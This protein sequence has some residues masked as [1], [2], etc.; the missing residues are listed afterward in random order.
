MAIESPETPNPEIDIDAFLNQIDEND[1][2]LIGTLAGMQLE[3]QLAG[4]VHQTAEDQLAPEQNPN[5]I[6]CSFGA[7]IACKNSIEASPDIAT[8]ERQ[9][10]EENAFRSGE[11]A[12]ERFL[13]I[14]EKR[15][16]E[17]TAIYS[18]YIR[19]SSPIDGHNRLS[20]MRGDVCRFFCENGLS[21][22]DAAT[23]ILVINELVTNYIRLGN[24]KTH[25]RLEIGQVT[26][27]GRAII[28]SHFGTELTK[29]E[30]RREAQLR[31]LEKQLTPQILEAEAP[32][33]FLN[34]EVE[35]HGLGSA[36]LG[37]LSVPSGIGRFPSEINPGNIY[38]VWVI[39]Q[40]A[41][42]RQAA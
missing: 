42:L 1:P 26:E 8:T 24:K 2:Q 13:A 9:V 25:G 17:Y 32:A 10:A 6:V 14:P 40:V 34:P 15:P 20:V 38:D 11:R 23:A 22:D 7:S 41:T 16:P 18:D 28:I 19:E 30:A 36:I 35:E 29:D 3:A 37:E 21:E 31:A 39:P 4:A 33:P 27:T 12:R 5:P